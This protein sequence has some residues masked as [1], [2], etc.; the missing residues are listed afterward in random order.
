MSL[1]TEAEQVLRTL[2]KVAGSL[3]GE[4]GGEVAGCW[5]AIKILAT[6]VADA[7]LKGSFILAYKCCGKQS[8][9]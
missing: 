6:G 4:M 3:R 1:S 7:D 8:Y 5:K 2:L 9:V